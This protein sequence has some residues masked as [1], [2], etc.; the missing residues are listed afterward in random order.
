MGLEVVSNISD[1]VATNPPGGDP[2]S[3]LDDHIRNLKT[4]LLA[5]FPSGGASFRGKFGYEDG[6][7]GTVV[8]ATSKSTA[9]TLNKLTGQITMHNAVLNAGAVVSF[10]LNNT[11]IEASDL[12]LVNIV[13]STAGAYVVNANC[14]G[15]AATITLSN[16]S[17]GN[18]G[19]AVQLRYAVIRGATV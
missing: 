11:T 13:A 14:I 15:G 3:Q 17:A 9:V 2:R 8:Q 1:L 16:I 18:L 6:S 7:G 19:E 4:A 12:L 5:D 10:T